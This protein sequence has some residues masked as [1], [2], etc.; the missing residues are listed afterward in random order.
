M[1][2]LPLRLIKWNKN[3]SRARTRGNL[4]ITLSNKV[5]RGRARRITVM[6]TVAGARGI[7]NISKEQQQ[8]G[9][10]KGGLKTIYSDNVLI[11]NVLF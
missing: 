11:I 7:D 3:A 5:A 8:K 4:G 1:R 6:I 2:H 9:G 10:L